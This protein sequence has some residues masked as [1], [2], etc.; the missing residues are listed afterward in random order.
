[1]TPSSTKLEM[2]VWLVGVSILCLLLSPTPHVL[3]EETYLWI[4]SQMAWLR[5]YDWGMPFSPFHETGFVFAHPPLFLWW[6]KL[7]GDGWWTGLPWLILWWWAV[8]RLYKHTQVPWRTGLCVSI[9]CTAVLLP[10]TR[11]AMPDLMTGALALSGLVIFSTHKS[12]LSTVCAGMLIGLAAWTK[13][14]ALVVLLAPIMTTSSLK[15]VG[16]FWLGAILIV[17]LG[18]FWLW[19]IYEQWHLFEVIEQ[20]RLIGRSPFES[21]LIG[22]PMRLG[23]SL[24]PIAM[25]RVFR[26]PLH[27]CVYCGIGAW[28]SGDLNGIWLGLGFSII[29]QLF[30][31]TPHKLWRWTVVL[32]LLGILVGH[33]YVS[34]RYWLLTGPL[35]W[36]LFKDEW[37]R[38][39]LLQILTIFVAS[40]VM[41]GLVY[42]TEKTHAYS[43]ETLSERALEDTT[44]ETFSG[45]WGMREVAQSKGLSQF[46]G[47]EKRLLVSHNSA[48]W[49][50]S[51]DDGWTMEQRFDGPMVYCR[52]VSQSESVGYYAD[53][54]GKA[55]IIC[56]STPKPIEV[57]EIWKRP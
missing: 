36:V 1:M 6:I 13:Y 38:L 3:D 22:I 28:V 41:S 15:R 34:P 21:R 5:P 39:G 48:G 30:R 25:I 9:C 12:L 17:M 31:P 37:T 53:S 56:S 18:E 24:F 42:W 46:Q 2:W 10:V 44:L 8:V 16:V 50:P 52:L 49:L 33:N 47:S 20:S 26:A 4:A 40:I 14:P 7:C 35:W 29:V 19:T 32:V 57:V 54:L 43:L 51:S 27:T 23:L 11:T 45:E 55:P